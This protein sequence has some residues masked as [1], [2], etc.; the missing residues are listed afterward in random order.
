VPSW[1]EFSANPDDNQ[2]NPPAGA[3]E[4]WAGSAANNTIRYV[5]AAIRSL[6]D[7]TL[8]IGAGMTGASTAGSMALETKTS[9]LDK[10][11]YD[12]NADGKVDAAATADNATK[13]GGVTPSA[14]VLT[15]LD[16]ADAAAARN[17]LGLGTA[18]T[19]ATG[20]AS[21]NVPLVGTVSATTSLAGLAALATA[22]EILA[23]TDSAKIAT[24]A[25][26][27]GNKSLAASGYYKLPGGLIVN[28]GKVFGASG[29]D[30]SETFEVAFPTACIAVAGTAMDTGTGARTFQLASTPTKTG[31]TFNVISGGSGRGVTA[32]YYIALGY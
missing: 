5:M 8:K 14:Y 6:G 1:S 12:S 16:D 18:A 19:L 22:A 15:V 28:W 30:N 29:A 20:T 3:P 31:F 11:T 4:G 32:A 7:T 21:G 27:A 9:Y 17:T 24:A 2:G 26:L 10:A 23:G 25:A 13:L